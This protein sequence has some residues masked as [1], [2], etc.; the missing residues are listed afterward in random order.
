M[1]LF[2]PYERKDTAKEPA[3]V[4][5]TEGKDPQ[6]GPTAPLRRRQSMVVTSAGSPSTS[7]PKNPHQP[8]NPSQPKDPSSSEPSNA[9]IAEERARMVGPRAKQGPTPTRKQ[10][11]AAR[12]ERLNPTLSSK[13]ARRR[14]S[15]AS[16]ETR[17]KEVSARE[18][19]PEKLLLRDHIDSRFNVGEVLLPALLILL[20]VSM[21]AAQFPVV[22]LFTQAAMY[23]FILG[24]VVDAVIMWRGFSKLLAE[25]IKNPERR[26]LLFYGMNRM[27]QFRRFRIPRPRVKRGDKM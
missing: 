16:R 15:S 2:K 5:V 9:E 17:M 10:A 21:L 4:E 13:E 1:G 19:T 24:V 20:A 25:R 3:P 6:N 8:K 23:V 12:R 27:I 18:S 26:G 22:S 11:E 7:R 14:S